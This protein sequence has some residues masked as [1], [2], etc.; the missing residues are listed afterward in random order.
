MA[1]NDSTVNIPLTNVVSHTPS[2]AAANG[3]S[4]NEK[5]G[6]F[7]RGVRGRRKAKS[8]DLRGQ[9]IRRVGDDGE[10]DV[11]TSMGRIYDKILNFSIITRYFL[12]VLPLALL[13]AIPIIVDSVLF[14]EKPADGQ[15]VP[16][17][18]IGGVRIKWFFTWIEIGTHH[19]S[20]LSKPI[21]T[22]YS[23]A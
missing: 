10:E 4:Y 23:M 17:R 13:I 22:S 21:L 6:L 14:A 7:H 12:Y 18:T 5:S 2:T 11:V 15:Q 9:A 19:R 16:G 8:E 20:S 3:N 1:N